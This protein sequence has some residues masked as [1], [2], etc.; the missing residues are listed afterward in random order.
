MPEDAAFG[1][2]EADAEV[3]TPRAGAGP[4]ATR[5]AREMPL[6]AAASSGAIRRRTPCVG[7]CSTTYGDLVC[8]GCKRFAHEIVGWNGYRERQRALVWARLR[9][10]AAQSVR[11]H[12]KV[13]DAALLRRAAIAAG[14][15]DAATLPAEAL[16]LE[17][18]RVR[19]DALTACGLAARRTSDAEDRRGLLATIDREFYA[20]SR[21]CYEASFKTLT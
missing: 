7:V 8:R 3:P 12:L 9:R 1:R 15:V 20:R 13:R 4:A 17:L 11:A 16:A 2:S 14:V 10:L 19:R 5:T 18:L 6:G 21:A